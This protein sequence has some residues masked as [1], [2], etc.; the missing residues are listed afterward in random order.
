MARISLGKDEPLLAALQ[1]QGHEIAHD[2]GGAL[3]CASCM[4][5]VREGA[6]RLD[7]AL[8]D[9]QDILDRAS[10]SQPGARLACQAAGPGG[11][12]ALDIPRADAPRL[13]FGPGARAVTLTERAA[14]HFAL[15]LAKHPDACGVRL[16]VEPAGCSGMGYRVDFADA[17][18]DGDSV[19]QT[20]PIRILVDTASLPYVQGASIDAVQEGLARRLRFD[21]PNVRQTCGCGESFGV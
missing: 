12:I 21:N 5:I 1:R 16:A 15:Q 4:V 11:E 19:F 20:G 7:P 10:F 9:E 8:E 2:C 6:E 13:A 14:R 18:R 3:A 17:V